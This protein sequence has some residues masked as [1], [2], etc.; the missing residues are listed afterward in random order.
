[1][2]KIDRAVEIVRGWSDEELKD[3]LVYR[4]YFLQL[5]HI[6]SFDTFVEFFESYSW[7]HC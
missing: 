3:F 2:K 4:I 1:M 7:C 5:G 6:Y